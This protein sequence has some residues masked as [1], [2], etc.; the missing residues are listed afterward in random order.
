MIVAAAILL[1]GKVH[2]M[3]RPA[4][5]VDI[6]VKLRSEGV[7]TTLGGIGEPG[8]IDEAGLFRLRRAAALHAERCGQV[9]AEAINW[10]LG[11]F[12]EDLW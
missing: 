1:G 6:R 7:L 4:R 10:N 9:K 11:L 12:T 8:F 2:S 3:P 5:H